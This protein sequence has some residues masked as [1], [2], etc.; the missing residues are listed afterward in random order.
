MHPSRWEACSISLLE[1]LAVGLP[2][3]VT[4]W[5]GHREWC[6]ED[7]A[8]YVDCRPQMNDFGRAAEPVP[9]SLR[10]QM[11]HVYEHQAEARDRGLRASAHIR[12]NYTWDAAARRMIELLG[13]GTVQVPRVAAR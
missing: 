6:P 8:Y 11:R 10:R 12:E 4:R 13:G 5:G 1:C 2:L 7:L 3:V 9:E